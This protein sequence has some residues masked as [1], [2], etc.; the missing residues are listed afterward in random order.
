MATDAARPSLERIA[1]LAAR[2][3]E[4]IRAGQAPTGAFV[5]CPNFPP[6]RYSW[7]RDGS[8]IADA[9]SRVGE[10]DSAEAFFGWCAQVVVDRQDRIESLIER[11]RAGVPIDDAE[12]L[13][14]RYTVDGRESTEDWS[15]FQLDGYGTWLWALDGHRRR[16]GRPLR[17]LLPGA[18][19]SAR[20]I[21]AFRERPCFDWW[22]ETVGMHGSTLAALFGGLAAAA[23]WE[24]LGSERRREFAAA[25]DSIREELMADAGERGAFAKVLGAGG[26]DASLLAVSTPFGV[27]DPHDP[28]MRAT[29]AEI[30]R[31][32]VVGGGVHRHPDDIYFGGG[33]WLLLAALLG[34]H[35]VETGRTD[36]AWTELDWIVA[37]ANPAGEL[38]EQVPDHLLAP[39]HFD[40]WPVPVAI[41]LLW[42][43]AMFLVLADALGVVD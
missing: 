26:I 16:H 30:E 8:F 3:V 33:Q 17:D 6:Y 43:H 22:E 29:L 32:L 38:P 14:T 23:G 13:N 39:D 10:T 21:A 12:F 18:E 31:T 25:A 24:E 40:D 35:H 15:E 11:H 4:I 41:P 28:P 5:A 1:D 2:S 36:D 42:S 37:H 27:V 9:M 7:L 20:Y 19:L 34:W